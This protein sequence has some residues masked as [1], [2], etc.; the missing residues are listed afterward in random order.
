MASAGVEKTMSRMQSEKQGRRL[1]VVPS[2][3]LAD[4]EA[5]GRGAALR[6]YYNP[7]GF[8]DEV[9]L[10]SPLE[11]GQRQAHGMTVIGVTEK[12]FRGRLAAIRPDVVRGYGGYWASD[13]VCQQRLRRVPVVVSVHD[14][15][16][17]LLHDSIAYADIVMC[18]S[19]SLSRVITARGVDPSRIRVV[20]NRID[21]TQFR[22]IT[23]RSM[24]DSVARRFPPGRSILHVGRKAREKN[25]DTLIRAL[26]LLPIDCFCVFV[27]LGDSTVY[28]ELALDM[29]VSQ[30]CFWIDS[31]SNGELPLWYS[32]CDCMCVPSRWEGFGIVFVEAAACGAA[33][34]TSNIPPMSDYLK[35]EESACLV[36]EY[37][38]P[39]AIAGQ[40]QSLFADRALSDRIS[41]GAMRAAAPFDQAAVVEQE[42]AVYREAMELR[43]LTVK[44]GLEITRWKE[45]RW[46]AQARRTVSAL[47]W[48]VAHTVNEHLGRVLSGGHRRTGALV[49]GASTQR[50]D[51]LVV[52]P[53]EAISVSEEAGYDNLAR[54]YNPAGMFS[55]VFVVSPLERGERQAHGLT[56]L[57]TT[58]REFAG[59]VRRL[60]PVA[61]RA[62]GGFWA[63]DL[64]CRRR[65]PGIP[66]IVSVHDPNP[67]M[68]HASIRY[69]DLVI[70][71]SRI[72]A[73]RVRARGVA[74]WRIRI[75]PN[76]IDPEIMRPITDE[77]RIQ[78]VARQFPPGKH[79]LHVGRKSHEKN[80]DTVVRALALLPDDY[81]AIFVGQ[82]D[83]TAY[84][85]LSRELGVDRRCFWIKSVWN[86]ELPVWYTWCDCLCVPSRWEGF[87]MVFIEAAACGTPIVTSD[88]PPMNAYLSHN[89][90]ANLVKDYEDPRALANALRSACG[91]DAYRRFLGKNAIRSVRSF[92]RETVDA[93]EVAIYKELL[94]M[95][96]LS[97]FRRLA[98][99]SWKAR[100][101]VSETIAQ[102]RQVVLARLDTVARQARLGL[103]GRAW[104][105]VRRTLARQPRATPL[106]LERASERTGE[107]MPR[108]EPIAI[109]PGGVGC[110]IRRVIGSVSDPV[111]PHRS[112]ASAPSRALEWVR[113]N[114]LQGGGIRVHSGHAHAYQEVT[115]YLVP[116]LAA[117][118]ERVL[119]DRLVRW[120]LCV[121]RA[122]GAFC[123]PDSATPYIFDTAQALRGLLAAVTW[124]PEARDAARRAADYLCQ[125]MVEGG[126]GGFGDKY[127]GTIPET[128]H[129]YALPPLVAA[130]SALEEPRF[131]EAA[132]A[133]LE[134][135]CH[136]RDFLQ[137]TS[138]THFLAYELEALI[139]LGRVDLAKPTLDMLRTGQAPSGA[140]PGCKGADWVCSPGLAQLA[141][142]WYKLGDWEPADRAMGWLEAHQEGD[143]GFKGSYGPNAGYLAA[144]ELSWAV[145]FFLD[146]H[147][148]RVAAFRD[149]SARNL[150]ADVAATD[151]RLQA[152]L[153]LI[154]QG[155]R[156]LEVGCRNGR[157]LKAI[158]HVRPDVACVGVDSSA[159]L[160]KTV[161]AGIE[162]RFGSSESIPCET[163]SVDVA[164]SIESIEHS[165]NPDVVVSE[166]VRVVRRGGWVVV[167]GK[168][169]AQ[170]GRLQTLSGERCPDADEFRLRLCREC[171][172]VAVAPVGFDGVPASEGLML[173]WKAKKR[174]RLTGGEWGNIL[175]AEGSAEELVG[176]V[177]FGDLTAW[178]TAVIGTTKQGDRV[179]EIGSGTGEISLCLALSGRRV[180]MVDICRESLGKSGELAGHLGVEVETVC[181]D[182]TTR[183]PFA[184]NT[185]DCVWSAGLLE[186]Y[187]AKERHDILLEW[188]RISRDKVIVLVPNADSLAYRLGKR[189][190]EDRGEWTYGIEL[191]IRTL[192]DEI[193]QV[194][195]ACVSEK[196]VGARHALTFLPPS[197]PLRTEL[198][199]FV[200]RYGEAEIDSWGNGYLL[201]TVGRKK[202]A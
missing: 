40:I 186:H 139:D 30:R 172:Q 10:L 24:L 131:G 41:R 79:I 190:K 128:I 22:R 169:N 175:A 4:Y 2:E 20:P 188:A 152:V 91:D 118:G 85:T 82:G 154:P 60:N 162:T 101:A 117:Y 107:S 14:P 130:A 61:V 38:D 157:F 70:C 129:L 46:S 125:Q 134:F 35:H 136:H 31:V 199:A 76:R 149:R 80:I 92:S 98:I 69:A 173:A 13:L 6:G 73:E 37:E 143:G 119:A 11:K 96:S 193:A 99:S 191:P 39:V 144:Y 178:A 5:K 159:E 75:M 104:R 187:T 106:A 150:P 67:T 17:I 74:S 15:N 33:I 44:R 53:S 43:P 28:R 176:R 68:V 123:C 18:V 103:P 127:R 3:S 184:D 183:L 62:Y 167:V 42:V 147:R 59:V 200:K 21:T 1:V 142:C 124:Q 9:Y 132:N 105:Y 89:I 116:T 94:A 166:L 97:P 51:R 146:A 56:I 83:E 120:L 110:I 179:L 111:T 71:M 45:K 16:P 25:I 121:Q 65:V 34:V 26:S 182:G 181:A 47:A 141:I 192:Q 109:R 202:N 197:S 63:S 93:Q 78:A 160:L 155:A 72:V 58:E 140:V 194:G 115:G 185:F 177:R 90:S 86:S 174:G 66:V 88:I 12:E 54:Y 171:D 153:D 158:G 133:C 148:L 135:Y 196:T 189:M 201:M 151:G 180:S 170:R 198:A 102:L 81:S 36:N 95:P 122:N 126:R 113:A 165:A 48:S 156:V 19:P 145:K 87:G 108:R 114:E 7:G 50:R 138:V 161:P 163:E 164:F 168:Q 137:L 77:S 84:R 49:N 64:A 55:E 57:G 27:G 52:V 29:G 100:L 32:W 23:D 112:E 195:L 8:F